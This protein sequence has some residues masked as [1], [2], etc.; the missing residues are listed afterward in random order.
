MRVTPGHGNT[1]KL[2]SSTARAG[3]LC[4]ALI[5]PDCSV[6]NE[7][8][9]NAG[10]GHFA[11]ARRRPGHAFHHCPARFAWSRYEKHVGPGPREIL[12]AVRKVAASDAWPL[13]GR[14]GF[15]EFST[16]AAVRGDPV[17][18][19]RMTNVSVRIPRCQPRQGGRG[20]ISKP[21]SPRAEERKKKKEKGNPILPERA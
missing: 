1:A 9:K 7:I 6:R 10:G 5:D 16:S 20:S 15:D 14:E 13:D 3:W 12:L 2:S 8:E 17:L 19:P 21:G 4:R 11:W 18:K